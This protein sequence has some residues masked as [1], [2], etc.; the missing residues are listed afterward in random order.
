VGER[1]QLRPLG[2]PESLVSQ[3]FPSFLAIEDVGLTKTVTGAV[4]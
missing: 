1:R 2:T 4:Y 3:T